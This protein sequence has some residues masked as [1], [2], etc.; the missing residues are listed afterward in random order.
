MPVKIVEKRSCETESKLSFIVAT[1]IGIINC[2]YSRGDLI[3]LTETVAYN[4]RQLDTNNLQ[5]IS[6][7]QASH[8]FTK[9]RTVSAC[10]CIGTC[11]TNRC[12]C[13]KKSIAC[14]SKCHRGKKVTCD[15]CS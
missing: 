3:D 1:E 2:S 7:I 5:S 4:L 11:S 9:F 15:N 6:V 14:C 12:P 8:H 13:K 10:K